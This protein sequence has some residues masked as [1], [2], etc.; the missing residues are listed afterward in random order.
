[1]PGL[2]DRF[3]RI[4]G[5]K[6]TNGNGQHE[7]KAAAPVSV[8]SPSV[9]AVENSDFWPTGIPGVELDRVHEAQA[10]RGAYRL[11][12]LAYVCIRYRAM[13]VREAPLMVVQ[14]TTDGEEWIENHELNQILAKPNVDYAMA[15]LVETTEIYL[16]TTGQCLWV[17][18]R[19]KAGRVA[20]IYPFSGDEFQIYSGNGRLFNVFR[21]GT[22]DIDPKDVCYFCYVD[23]T[24]PLGGLAPLFVALSHLRLSQHIV[25]RATYYL[26]NAMIP[27]AIYTPDKEWRPGATEFDRLRQELATMFQGVKSGR[28]AIA[29]GGGKF[30]QGWSL[31]EMGTDKLWQQAEAMICAVFGVP[32]A[33][34]GTV[35]GLENSP[36]SHLETAKRSFYDETIL[37][38]WEFIE[39]VLT[40]S[41]LREVDDKENHY[42]RFDQSRIRALQKDLAAQAAIGATAEKWTSV[43]ER[44][45][46]MGFDAKPDPKADEIPELQA[47]EPIKLPGPDNQDRE[48]LALVKSRSILH[49]TKAMRHRLW[50]KFDTKAKRQESEYEKAAQAQF[51]HE[52]ASI[53]KRFEAATDAT[54]LAALEKIRFAYTRKDGQYHIEWLKRYEK[55]IEDTINVAGKDLGAE[56]GFDFHLSNPKVQVAVLNR[57]NKLTKEVTDTTYE[58]IRDVVSEGLSKGE[59][60]A[61]IAK[62]IREDV[63][64]GEITKARATTIARTETIGALSE[65][66]FI[67]AEESGFIQSKEWLTQGDS[68]VRHSHEEIDGQK[69]PLHAAFSNGLQY[70]GDQKGEAEEVINCRCSLLYHDQPYSQTGFKAQPAEPESKLPDIHVNVTVP[71]REPEAKTVQPP[72]N[73]NM[74]IPEKIVVREVPNRVKTAH[75]KRDE[76]GNSTITITEKFAEPPTEPKPE[77]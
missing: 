1:M 52:K 2:I 15:R 16:C 66:E 71:E 45:V 4:F 24:N 53:L 68:R 42:I 26:K 3:P 60:S 59:G 40:D 28:A 12:A 61:Q 5:V 36:W 58:K 37:P 7:L 56:I 31:K 33:L 19:D 74:T 21:I 63:F 43:N 54:I 41:L 72:M 50:L 35:I 65:G 29:E 75:I 62:R 8:I 73:F 69:Q 39:G 57:T 23:P 77:E 18:N 76:L 64:G 22:R 11:A 25:H 14:E 10:N 49:E 27:G 20:S 9:L 34:I 48:E 6:A 38:E 47:P 13:K 32:A 44:R 67:A 46:L 30:E 17:K 70:P 55:L 51:E